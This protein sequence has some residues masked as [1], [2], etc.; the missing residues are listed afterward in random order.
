[1]ALNL[2]IPRTRLLVRM[3][4]MAGG[5]KPV[6]ADADGV[7]LPMQRRSCV[8]ASYDDVTEVTVTFAV[9]GELIRMLPDRM[10]VEKPE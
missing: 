8:E 2:G 4:E 9:D 5:V 1:M 3:V 6:L 10:T 7:P